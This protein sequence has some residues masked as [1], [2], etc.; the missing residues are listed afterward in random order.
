M[1]NLALSGLLA[2]S[3]SLSLK[4]GPA[5]ADSKPAGFPAALVASLPGVGEGDVAEQHRPLIGLTKERL[6][7]MLP[8]QPKRLY[9]LMN[10]DLVYYMKSKVFVLYRKG[11]VVHVGDDVPE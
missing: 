9:R 8:T 4:A 11:R 3:A 10:G 2:A 6:E 5:P 1:R 7:K